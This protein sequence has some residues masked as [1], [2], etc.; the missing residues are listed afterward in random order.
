MCSGTPFIYKVLK[1]KINAIK[2]KERKRP[3]F[4]VAYKD[5]RNLDTQTFDC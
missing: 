2:I 3:I 4:D 5:W 1:K